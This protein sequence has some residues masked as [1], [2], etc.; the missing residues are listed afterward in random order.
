[1][2]SHPG[3]TTTIQDV[4]SLIQISFTFFE[5]SEYLL[6]V[7]CF[8]RPKNGVSSPP[9]PS[10][11]GFFYL[12]QKLFAI[13]FNSEI[14]VLLRCTSFVCVCKSHAVIF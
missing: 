13:K 1:M 3:T 5:C 11:L 4:F 9:R 10:F 2:I 8:K 7:F 12:K 6:G 14:K